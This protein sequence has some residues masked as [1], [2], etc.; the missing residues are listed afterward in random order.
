MIALDL[1]S[2]PDKCIFIPSGKVGKALNCPICLGRVVL[3]SM[4]V[5]EKFSCSSH[6]GLHHTTV[7]RVVTRWHEFVRS[8]RKRLS[9]SSGVI[10]QDI[11]LKLGNFNRPNEKRRRVVFMAVDESHPFVELCDSQIFKSRQVQAYTVINSGMSEKKTK[12][13]PPHRF[14]FPTEESKNK[15]SFVPATSTPAITIAWETQFYIQA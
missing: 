15:K 10:V 2:H 7:S 14:T 4:T 12:L 11:M 9:N 8:R 6:H 5:N 3:S 13:I 1:S